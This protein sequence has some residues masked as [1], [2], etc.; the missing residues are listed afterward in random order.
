MQSKFKLSAAVA[1]GI[2]QRLHQGVKQEQWLQR[3]YQR[4]QMIH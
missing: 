3:N 2:M 4:A 1:G